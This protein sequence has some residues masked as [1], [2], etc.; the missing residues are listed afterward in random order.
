MT[1]RQWRIRNRLAAAARLLR[2]DTSVQAVAQ[3]VGSTHVSAVRRVFASHDGMS[4]TEY[5]KRF[6]RQSRTGGD[7]TTV[8]SSAHARRCGRMVGM[9]SVYL[10]TDPQADALLTHDRFALM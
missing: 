1:L 9:T 6:R 3:R 2:G 7:P 5:R 10:S 8:H 4:P